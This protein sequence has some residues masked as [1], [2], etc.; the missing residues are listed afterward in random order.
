MEPA[1]PRFC[2]AMAPSTRSIF[3]VGPITSILG[4]TPGSGTILNVANTNA[5]ANVVLLD[6][7]QTQVNGANLAWGNSSVYVVNAGSASDTTATAAAVAINRAYHVANV[8]GT[9]TP[10]GTGEY[11]TFLTKDAAG[12]TL[13]W[14]WGLDGRSDQRH[15]SGNVVGRQRRRQW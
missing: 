1:T 13:V 14:F 9:S 11:V 12:D 8:D 15:H 6:G 4:F 10:L 2:L 7:S 5:A 3:W